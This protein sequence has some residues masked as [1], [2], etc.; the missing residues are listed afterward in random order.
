MVRSGRPGC[1]QSELRAPAALLR[2][3]TNSLS[4][5][6]CRKHMINH[7]LQVSRKRRYL[8][9]SA[10]TPSIPWESH[11]PGLPPPPAGISGGGSVSRPFTASCAQPEN[12]KQIPCVTQIQ[13]FDKKLLAGLSVVTAGFFGFRLPAEQF[14]N[15]PYSEHPTLCREHKRWRPSVAPLHRL[16]RSTRKQKTNSLRHL[17]PSV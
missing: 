16:L 13:V 2:P 9:S 6:P 15:L 8:R 10:A 11:S 3:N 14:G 12:R 5:S 7:R 1:V 17:D 4:A